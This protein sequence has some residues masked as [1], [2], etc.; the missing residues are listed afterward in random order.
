MLKVQLI[1]LE[2]ERA[3][4]LSELAQYVSEETLS[5]YMTAVNTIEY[6]FNKEMTL[7][8]LASRFCEL[9]R[10]EE[11]IKIAQTFEN[12]WTRAKT[13]AELAPNLSEKLLIETLILVKD[14]TYASTRVEILSGLSP[15]LVKFPRLQLFEL[16]QD[17]LP[18][19]AIYP[20]EEL[21]QDLC[22]LMPVIAELGGTEGLVDIAQAVGEVVT[23]WS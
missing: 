2:H 21:L 8:S 3:S 17:I 22:A 12:D 13:L 19:L 14:I 5:Q 23:W 18:V 11:A 9:G 10:H 20:R 1:D 7:E 15:E 4:V 6:D 16:W